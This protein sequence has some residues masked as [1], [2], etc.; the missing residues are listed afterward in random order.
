MRMERIHLVAYRCLDAQE[1]VLWYRRMLI[2]DFVLAIAE[3]GAARCRERRR[4]RGPDRC[5]ARTGAG[6]PSPPAA[7]KGARG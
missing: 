4:G 7:A 2:L 1:T 3:E 6:T 5:A